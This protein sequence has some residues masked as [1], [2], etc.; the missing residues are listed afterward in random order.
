MFPNLMFLYNRSIQTTYVLQQERPSVTFLTVTLARQSPTEPF[1]IN[2]CIPTYVLSSS[3][4]SFFVHYSTSVNIQWR[5]TNIS[6]AFISPSNSRVNVNLKLK[7]EGALKRVCK[8]EQ[9]TLGPDILVKWILR[10]MTVGEAMSKEEGKRTCNRNLTRTG[11]VS[12]FLPKNLLRNKQ[13][14]RYILKSSR[15]GNNLLIIYECPENVDVHLE[16]PL[17]YWNSCLF[18]HSRCHLVLI[19]VSF[20][21]FINRFQLWFYSRYCLSM[22]TLYLEPSAI[23]PYLSPNDRIPVVILMK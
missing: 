19:R 4:S 23:S 8:S 21:Y 16:H 10:L 17:G 1:P 2:R 3:S 14:D 9:V 5:N 12:L 7:C 18:Y 20:S 22:I 6:C 11:R 13:V 15:P